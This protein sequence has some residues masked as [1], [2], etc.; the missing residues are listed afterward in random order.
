[1]LEIRDDGFRVLAGTMLFFVTAG[2]GKGSVRDDLPLAALDLPA[3][4]SVVPRQTERYSG[5][6]P[7]VPLVRGPKLYTHC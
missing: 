2:P 3:R 7:T 1:M 4:I 5:T 6:G